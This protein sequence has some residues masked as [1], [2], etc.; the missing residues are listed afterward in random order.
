MAENAPGSKLR[1][2][3]APPPVDPKPG[4]PPPPGERMVP[5]SR[6][7]AVI[8]EKTAMEVTIRALK[9]QVAS[10]ETDAVVALKAEHAKEA[11][12]W[13]EERALLANGVIDPYDVGQVRAHFQAAV[14]SGGDA[15]PKDIGTYLAGIKA[16]GAVVPKGLSYLVTPEKPTALAGFQPPPAPKPGANGKPP[17]SAGAVTAAALK[18]ATDHGQSTGDWAQFDALNAAATAARAAGTAT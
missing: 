3:V 14:T 7:N 2:K 11:A 10:A 15:A 5:V 8:A 9:R 17:P 13:A 18:R 12:G 4:D 1:R 16:E 6:L